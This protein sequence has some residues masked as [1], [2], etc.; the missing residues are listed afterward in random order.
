MKMNVFFAGG[1]T[2]QR[3]PSTPQS[4][5]LRLGTFL[6]IA[7]G[8]WYSLLKNYAALGLGDYAAMLQTV[9]NTTAMFAIS[10]L[11]FV[12]ILYLLYT[13]FVRFAYN[14]VVRQLYFFDAT[15]S[16]YD[17]RL[18]VDLAAIAVCV[19]KALICVLYMAY[20]LYESVIRAVLHPIVAALAFGGA[21]Y[22]LITKVGKQNKEAVICSL[23]ILFCLP[24]LFA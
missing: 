23:S 6:A 3:M 24:L 17:F 4:I 5:L 21:L 16:I 15:L 14:S 2:M 22:A 20:P 10:Y 12:A 9:G 18:R 7:A 19:F 1:G 13:L 11:I 8:S